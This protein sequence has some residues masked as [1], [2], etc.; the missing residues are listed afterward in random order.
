MTTD[1]KL[2]K[3]LDEMLPD[4]LG[5]QCNL[6]SLFDQYQERK[7]KEFWMWCFLNEKKISELKGYYNIEQRCTMIYELY[8]KETH[9]ESK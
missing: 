3:K 9:D 4:K 1:E 8:R 7:C 2:I 5:T 6:Y